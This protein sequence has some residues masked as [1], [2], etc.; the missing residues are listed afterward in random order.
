MRVTTSKFEAVV[1]CQKTVD[2]PLW[3]GS[4]LLPQA[5]EFKEVTCEGRMEHEMHWRFGMVSAV[6]RA[7]RRT[8]LVKKELSQKA[9]LSIYWSIYVQS[10]T[11][12]HELWVET[13]RMRWRIQAAEISLEVSEINL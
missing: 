1:L 9:K 6:T 4:E 3:V 12:G 2:W 11:Y 7:L 8:I 13:E 5:K 10:L